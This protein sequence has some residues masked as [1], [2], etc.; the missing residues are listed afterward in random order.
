VDVAPEVR[1]C[2]PARELEEFCAALAETEITCVVCG[3][4]LPA[5]ST[6]A[7]AVQVFVDPADDTVS[8]VVASHTRC[9]PSGVQRRPGLAAQFSARSSTS[10]TELDIRWCPMTLPSGHVGVAWEASERVVSWQDDP[11][12]AV[13]ALIA[14]Y[15]GLGFALVT[16]GQI[17]RDA[18]PALPMLSGW[19]AKLGEDGHLVVL[20][21]DGNAALSVDVD[22]GLIQ[23]LRE[24]MKDKAELV[25]LTG[26]N[27]HLDSEH[28]EAGLAYA[29]TQG[30]LVGARIPFAGLTHA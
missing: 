20:S 26:C 2:V 14:A 8:T 29:A 28:R 10:T 17:E 13:T 9:A 25:A 7:V 11:A 23:Q 18:L 16:P 1:D 3:E 12:D 4:D 24:A 22:A 21:P 15:L 27:L 30:S 5:G 6:T 19:Q